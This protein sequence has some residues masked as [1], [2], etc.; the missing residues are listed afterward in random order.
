MPEILPILSTGLDPSKPDRMRQGICLGLAELMQ[1]AS[2]TLIERYVD[3]LVE[4][5]Q[6]ALCDNDAQVRMAAAGA[7]QVL[8]DSIGSRAVDDIIPALLN[9]VDSKD[10]S[11][12]ERALAGLQQILAKKSR[13]ILP[14]LILKLLSKPITESH[15]HALAGVAHVTGETIHYH[16]DA[17]LSSLFEECAVARDTEDSAREQVIKEAVSGIVLSIKDIGVQWLSVE[18][19]KYC[20]HDKQINRELGCLEPLLRLRLRITRP[21]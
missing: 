13:G 21:S 12:S 18:L 17:I 16:M 11:E 4:N 8:Q 20:D 5:V 10:P 2:T 9:T 15:I 19:S 1:S 3:Q 6:R 7:F 14:Y